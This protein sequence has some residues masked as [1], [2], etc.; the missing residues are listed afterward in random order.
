MTSAPTAGA[1]N[2][3][4]TLWIDST[5]LADLSGVDNDTQRID[6]ARWG[7]VEGI[8]SGTH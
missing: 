2:G 7:A 6:R 4:P 5:Q 3:G 8:D 1:N